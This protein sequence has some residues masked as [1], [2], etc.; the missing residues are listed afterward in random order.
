[1]KLRSTIRQLIGAYNYSRSHYH[2]YTSQNNFSQ[3]SVISKYFQLH[4]QL[5][6]YTK[7]LA[8][9]SNS[10]STKS[11]PTKKPPPA[12][13]AKSAPPAPPDWPLISLPPRSPYQ[14]LTLET[15]LSSQI[16]TIPN[17]WTSKLCKTYVSFLKTL[18]LITTPG[19]PKKG[20]AV[21]VNDRFQIDDP[22]FAERLWT[23]TGLRE[24]ISGSGDYEAEEGGMSQD[25]RRELW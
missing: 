18:P 19:K 21:R 11:K 23:E 10:M 14:P 13:N 17:F 3:T 8:T 12:S 6:H 7:R 25:E 5:I 22:V 15:L 4:K 2:L 20:H 9:G 24:C 1:M 16:L